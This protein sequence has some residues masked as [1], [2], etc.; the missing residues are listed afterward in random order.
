MTGPA[1][2]K[3]PKHDNRQEEFDN[4]APWRES[5]GAMSDAVPHSE[6]VPAPTG[7][8]HTLNWPERVDA[9][10][11]A[12]PLYDPR[13]EKDACGIGFVANIKGRASHQIVLDAAHVLAN[14]SHRGACGCEVNT[15]DG[16][17]MLTGLPHEFLA[18]V[19]HATFGVALPE[20]GRFAAGNV[21]LPTDASERAH[22]KM[23]IG[24]MLGEQGL[25]VIGWRFVPIDPDGAD[26]G[27]TARAS[28]PAIEQLF[29]AAPEAMDE[30]SFERQLYLVRKRAGTALR[31]DARLRERKLVYFCSLSARTLVYKGMLTAEQLMPFFPDLA[32][33]RFKTHLA[34]IHSRF[35]TNTFPSW[36]RAQ[37]LRMLSHNGEINTVSGNV[38]AMRSRER[39]LDS[40]AFGAD[41][42]RLLPVAEPDCSDS[43]NFDNVLEFLVMGGRDIAHAMTMMIP[44]AWQ[45]DSEMSADK[46][47]FYEYHSCLM[48]PWDGPASMVFTDG[49]RIGAVLD[50]N[51]LRPSRY[52][53]THDDR[54]IMASEVGVLELDPELI[55]EK[56]RLQP[57]RLFL[58]DFRQRR[59][60]PDAEL[61]DVLAGSQPWARWLGE[62]RMFLTD[63]PDPTV[64]PNA[65]PATSTPPLL[66][67]LTAFGY[68]SETMQ[69]TLLPLAETQTDPLGSMGND[70]ALACLSSEPRLVYDYFK[71]L[72]AQVTNP[73]IDPIR[74][75]VV[76]SL[77][78][79]IGP[80]QNLLT[81]TPE[82]ARRI[83]LKHPILSDSELRKLAGLSGTAG[84]TTTGRDAN[85]A[86]FRSVTI[87]ITWPRSRGAAGLD[88]SL[89][90]LAAEAERAVD[91]GASFLIL[92]D[93]A[94]SETRV[95]ISALLAVG[96]VHSHLVRTGKRTRVG[97]IVA[98][99][100][101]ARDL[102]VAGREFAGIEPAMTYLTAATKHVLGG[103]QPLIDAAGKR[104][105]V[106]GGGDTGTDCI[107][108]ALRQGAT[109]VV[110][111][112]IRPRPTKTRAPGNSWP[113]WPNVFRVDYGHDEVAAAFGSGPRQF[114]VATTHFEGQGGHVTGVALR[115]F[116]DSSEVSDAVLPADLVLLAMGFTGPESA[117]LDAFGVRTDARSNV[118]AKI[119]TFLTNVDGVFAAGD[120]RRGQSLVVTAIAEGRGAARAIDQWLMGDTRLQ[121]PAAMLRA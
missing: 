46:R 74:E 18:A 2:G 115:S 14:M 106:I 80:E 58:V 85:A 87:D 72:F 4:C 75:A 62:S 19:A 59:L 107:G 40:A 120:C 110:N 55:R 94:T 117:L 17:G 54:V 78:C 88:V 8:P 68:T 52:I 6:Q 37:P 27:P 15:G 44:E 39:A 111:L 64:S 29:V 36:D 42:E 30:A 53:L 24:R 97:L 21:F 105:I 101:R 95:P 90:S 5:Q 20:P 31:N 70:A 109:S 16:A 102:D 82:H 23:T 96:A 28:M 113:E 92:S 69:F 99:A 47:A 38:N 49:D 71:Q 112:E 63:L 45:S 35:S 61:K 77:E 76:M 50:R 83:V 103:P 1:L 100:T 57:G 56:G 108:T 91:D 116:A 9:L 89:T 34:I 7:L 3:S 121:A 98:G 67:R 79:P 119:P 93:R 73:P 26:I 65:S 118:A 32:D 12:A 11:A 60:I 43:G 104:V 22:C 51:G 84:T 66:P 114:S 86:G 33:W 48:E 10:V 41:L 13:T 81:A 25:H